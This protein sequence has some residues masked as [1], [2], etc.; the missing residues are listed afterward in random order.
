MDGGRAADQSWPD[1]NRWFAARWA[2]PPPQARKRPGRHPRAL[3]TKSDSISHI[4]ITAT[5]ATAQPAV[6]FALRRAAQIDRTADLLLALGK[7]VQ[8]ERLARRAQVG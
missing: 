7:H 2:E 3:A 5:D 8:A 4:T 6:Q 1:N